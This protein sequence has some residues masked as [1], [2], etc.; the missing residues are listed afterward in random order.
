[1][2][3]SP[4][5]LETQETCPNQIPAEGSHSQ[6]APVSETLR[7]RFSRTEAASGNEAQGASDQEGLFPIRFVLPNTSLQVNVHPTMTLDEIRR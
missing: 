3:G 7:A 1:M 4:D 5:Q 6:E 2:S